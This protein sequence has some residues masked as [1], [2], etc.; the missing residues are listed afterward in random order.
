[1]EIKTDFSKLWKQIDRIIE[2]RLQPENEM[3]KDSA[4]EN[5][6]S[7]GDKEQL[8]PMAKHSSKLLENL[9]KPVRNHELQSESSNEMEL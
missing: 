9:E 3:K 6:H 7:F 2:N 8:D 5:V 1:M 4:Y